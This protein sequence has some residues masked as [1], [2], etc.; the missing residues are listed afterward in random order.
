MATENSEG[1]GG[2]GPVKLQDIIEQFEA[3]IESG[4]SA[5]K[6]IARRPERSRMRREEAMTLQAARMLQDHGLLSII[7]T[8]SNETI[9]YIAERVK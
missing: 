8:R 2:G 4:K 9:S 1:S 3:W 5:R 6:V 7:T